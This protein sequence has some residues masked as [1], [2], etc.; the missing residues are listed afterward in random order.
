MKLKE[1]QDLVP[2]KKDFKYSHKNNLNLTYVLTH[3]KSPLLKSGLLYIILVI[4]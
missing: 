1:Q 4:S 3:T 2:N